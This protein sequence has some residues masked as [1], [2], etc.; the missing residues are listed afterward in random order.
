MRT[1]K[2]RTPPGEFFL[3]LPLPTGINE[4]HVQQRSEI[5][6][7]AD[8]VVVSPMTA[9]DGPPFPAQ[10]FHVSNTNLFV[11]MDGL[12]TFAEG[13]AAHRKEPQVPHPWAQECDISES[14]ISLTDC[15]FAKGDATAEPMD[16]AVRNMKEVMD[17]HPSALVA[18]DTVSFEAEPNS[19]PGHLSSSTG[20]TSVMGKPPIASSLVS[21]LMADAPKQYGAHFPQASDISNC[22]PGPSVGFP[23]ESGSSATWVHG[24]GNTGAKLCGF[25]PQSCIFA[26][27]SV[28][29]RP[30]CATYIPEEAVP[31]AGVAIGSSQSVKTS[32]HAGSTS[33]PSLDGHGR[34]RAA[35]VPT[36]GRCNGGK[37][38]PFCQVGR[39]SRSLDLGAMQVLE[40]VGKGV[41]GTVHRV[42]LDDQLYA[43]KCIDVKE[44]TEASSVVEK[45]SRERGLVKEL[46]MIRL[47]RA[48]R[49]PEYLIQMFSAAATV[50][51]KKQ[52]LHVLMELMSFSVEDAQRMVS[53]IPSNEMKKK[54]QSTFSKHLS[55]PA[56]VRQQI[57]NL[58]R[59]QSSSCMHV[60]G[61]TSYNMAEHW[62]LVIDRQS[63][64][65]EI[66]LSMIAADVLRGLRELHEEYAIVHCDIKP[67]NILL[68]FDMLRFKV[69]DFGCGC[70]MHRCS[71]KVRQVFVDLGSKLY[72]APERLQD[73]LCDPGA[74]DGF[75]EFEFTPAV[76]VWSLGIMLLELS[77]GVHP[78]H[79][80]KSDYWN[81][82]NKLRLP[83]MV[84]PSSWSPALYDFTVRCLMRSP[85]QRW[86]VNQLLQH[87]F[88]LK[89]DGIP[90]AKL[91]S[92]M[93]WLKV[94]SESFQRRQQRE[95]LE[96]QILLSTGRAGGRAQQNESKSRW[97]AFTG[98]LQVAPQFEDV[99]KFPQLI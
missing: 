7:G 88:V 58:L 24:A 15:T 50:D 32:T 90:R 47:Q 48:R 76:D 49:C 83:C 84:K 85:E 82:G 33:C 2:V 45:Q 23:I 78:C 14:T 1:R 18:R 62:E 77:N 39:A 21:T 80:F 73:E 29:A 89:Y 4:L 56:M 13:K 61:R 54:T 55:G 59:Q 81:Y 8:D 10:F 66:I 43:L 12:P 51:S 34:E 40:V 35:A 63:P 93:A 26:H 97:E 3:D 36:S 69:A 91:R 46:N 64:M 60:I 44:V 30:S 25:L 41:Q 70:Q 19:K 92:W 38:F 74:V 31:V 22:F 28:E 72:K 65:P 6:V 37:T 20:E 75:S 17:G 5:F 71:G 86:T 52:Q 87:P 79:P 16:A 11:L 27:D 99:E 42:M 9:V 94:E 68:D 95:L 53:R 67:A 98:F 57:Q 96:K